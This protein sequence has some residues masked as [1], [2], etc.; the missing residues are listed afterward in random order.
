MYLESDAY[1]AICCKV[2]VT[3]IAFSDIVLPLKLGWSWTR[4]IPRGHIRSCVR[5]TARCVCGLRM[6]TCTVNTE[7]ILWRQQ[8]HCQL[9]HGTTLYSGIA[10]KVSELKT[11]PVIVWL[12]NNITFKMICYL[13]FSDMFMR[14]FDHIVLWPCTDIYC[15]EWF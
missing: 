13:I 11:R 1:W 4:G 6:D 14:S 10:S 15:I 2:V 12:T 5:L 3:V 9:I 8:P 7:R